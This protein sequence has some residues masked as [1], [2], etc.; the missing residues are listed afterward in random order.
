MD[1]LKTNWQD[2]INYLDSHAW[3]KDDWFSYNIEPS[4]PQKIEF[5]WVPNREK[6]NTIINKVIINVDLY[7][8]I[9]YDTYIYVYISIDWK[10][11]FDTYN[12][13][14]IPMYDEELKKEDFSD[15]DINFF[16]TMYN[17]IYQYSMK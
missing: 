15:I 9:N 6:L 4:F 8:E 13:R 5:S 10:K 17:M 11:S 7:K 12:I 16:Y 14:I 2:L 3:M 1:K